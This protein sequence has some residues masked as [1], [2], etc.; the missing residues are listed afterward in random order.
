MIH[1][2]TDVH[3]SIQEAPIDAA[4]AFAFLQEQRAGALDIFVGTTRQF[5]GDKETQKLYYECYE[6]MALSEIN[7]VVEEAMNQWELF[8]VVV[9][10]RIGEVPLGEASVV[11]GV[12][13]AHR[14][15]AFA[16][17]RFLI[18]TLKKQVPIWKREFY[19]NGEEE[20]V[21]GQLPDGIEM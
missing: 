15:A 6:P 7:R 5:T 20:W 16:S 13:T 19:R 1:R 14:D 11:I 21:E 4:N 10:H 8:K 18:D 9:I 2:K 17:C 3:V 12:A